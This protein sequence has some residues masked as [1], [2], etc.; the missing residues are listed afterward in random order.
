MANN[1]L[2][3]EDGTRPAVKN[4]F[5]KLMAGAMG[6][7]VIDYGMRVGVLAPI[8]HVK[9]I[10]RAFSAFMIHLHV[11]VV[12]RKG[13][14][15]VD[16]GRVVDRVPTQLGPGSG[17]MKCAQA[18]ALNLVVLHARAISETHVDD[19]ISQV[20]AIIVRTRVTLHDRNRTVLFRQHQDT[21]KG[22][23]WRILSDAL[24]NKYKVDWR[25]DANA[26]RNLQ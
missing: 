17:D 1:H 21:R 9:P 19:C 6:L 2:A 25:L 14:A 7:L 22:R 12:A 13:R 8:D 3:V 16:R 26:A 10:N 23:R 20:H 18:F 5:V 15:K 11:N 4:A 24:T